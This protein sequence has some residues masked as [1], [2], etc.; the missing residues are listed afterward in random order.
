MMQAR[1]QLRTKAGIGLPGLTIW[2]AVFGIA[3]YVLAG[4]PPAIPALPTNLPSWAS[5][6]V[7]LRSPMLSI[8]LALPVARFA[9]WLVWA[10][11]CVTV[12]LRVAINTLEGATKG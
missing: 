3:V 9:A 12:L 10:W 2:L 7:W 8:D 6:E 1:G 5:V 11:T 4:W